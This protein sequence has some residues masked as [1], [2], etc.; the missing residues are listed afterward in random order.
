MKLYHQANTRSARV[1]W[2]L[3]ELDTPHETEIVD[4]FAGAGR[5]PEYQKIHPHGFVPALE[6]DGTVLIESAAICMYLV[7]RYGA[8]RD[9][10]PPPG[11]IERGKYYEWMVYLPATA[12]P[13][14]ETIMFHTVFL[15]E[16]HRIPQLVERAKKKW[17]SKIEPRIT[18]AI[19]T[20]PYV[21]GDRFTAVDVMVASTLA[22]ARM[23]GILGEAPE[24]GAYLA[25]MAARP[26]F[27]KAFT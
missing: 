5:R 23:A 18:G 16:S 10:A 27:A 14:L 26:A 12:D 21:L 4:V 8:G 11:T 3:A 24:I 20:S 13:A 19:V 25:R 1:R 7:D 15:P 2:L 17:T 6:D 22:W 9:L